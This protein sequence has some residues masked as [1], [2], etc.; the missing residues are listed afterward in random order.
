MEQPGD[1][2]DGT[3]GDPEFHR[4]AEKRPAWLA[5]IIVP[6]ML[7]PLVLAFRGSDGARFFHLFGAICIVSPCAGFWW[8]E[9]RGNTFEGRAARGC[10]ATLGLFGMYL[11]WALLCVPLLLRLFPPLP[12]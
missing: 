4:T 1:N 5:W 3:V 2:P 6:L 7:V 10:L 11:V 9:M 8:G 12:P